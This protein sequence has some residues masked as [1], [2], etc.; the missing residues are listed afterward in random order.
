[1]LFFNNILSIN[2]LFIKWIC[3]DRGTQKKKR[4]KKNNIILYVLFIE[5]LIRVINDQMH[6]IMIK[7]IKKMQRDE[8]KVIFPLNNY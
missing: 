3:K 1:M 8:I 5:Q 4:R 6:Y 7:C 2:F